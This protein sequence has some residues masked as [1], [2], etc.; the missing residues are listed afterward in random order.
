MASTL[1]IER[2]SLTTKLE[3]RYAA[4]PSLAN[5]GGGSAKD[6]GTNR[7]VTSN[8]L[9]Q[10]TQKNFTIRQPIQTTTFTSSALDYAKKL[11]ADT[12]KYRG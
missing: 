10:S 3:D 7:A 5:V 11:G 6:V 2:P 1:P 4:A 8:P 12:R 9:T